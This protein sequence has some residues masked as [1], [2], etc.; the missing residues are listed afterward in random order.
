MPGPVAKDPEGTVVGVSMFP[1]DQV[2]AALR[3]GPIG[4]TVFKSPMQTDVMAALGVLVGLFNAGLG[5]GRTSTRPGD[6]ADLRAAY[7]LG[8]VYIIAGIVSLISGQFAAACWV[9]FT[10][11]VNIVAA[12]FAIVGVVLYVIDLG[13]ASLVW[14]CNLSGRS[15]HDHDGSCVYV[16]HFAQSL[17][18][19]MDITLIVLAVLQLCVCISMAVLCIRALVGLEEEEVEDD[20]QPMCEDQN[21]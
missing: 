18:T 20:F 19:A 14:I 8:A 15:L 5:S 16:A 13:D 2:L 21:Q 9:G 17:L 4:S 1:L 12:I 10:A 7:W 6:L 3:F 11:L